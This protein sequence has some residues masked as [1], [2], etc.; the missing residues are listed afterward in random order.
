MILEIDNKIEVE[1]KE[2]GK[3]KEKLEVSYRYP[4]KKDEK[5]LE[6]EMKR[7][8]KLFK[9]MTK[10]AKK[11]SSLEKRIEY[12][13]KRGDYEKA[14]KLFEE[15]EKLEAKGDKLSAD[16]EEAG[17]EEWAENIS[18]RRFDLLVGGKDVDR[19]REYAEAMSYT[20]VLAELDA[21]RRE[22]EGKRSKG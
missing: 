3:T 17:G 21:A 9:E 10:L 11:I 4:T 7:I 6:E 8:K 15:K 22:I 5:E 14:E 1:I 18:K 2:G 16:I 20:R 13:E 19:L 12:A